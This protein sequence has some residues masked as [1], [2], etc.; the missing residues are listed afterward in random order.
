MAFEAL[1]QTFTM[2]PVSRHYNAILSI[3][4]KT[5]ASDFT[6]GAVLSQNEDRVQPVAFYSK[7]MTATELNY[8]IQDKE[9]LAIVSAF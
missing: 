6:I 2:A 4:V 7:Y 3:I 8:D 1:K 9:M 5:D